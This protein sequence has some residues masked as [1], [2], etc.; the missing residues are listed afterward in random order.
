MASV[1]VITANQ[2]RISKITNGIK[3]IILRVCAYCRVSTDEQARFGF[4]IQAQKDALEKY[5]KQNDYK[6]EFYIDEGISA[7][8]MKKRIALN[9]ML[10]KSN[11]FD[12]VLFTKLDRLS[13]NVLDAN[14][15][16]KLLQDN[17][18]LE[19]EKLDTEGALCLSRVQKTVLVFLFLLVIL[20]LAPNF[21]PKDFF[22]TRS[23][24]H[25]SELQSPR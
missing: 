19:T 6:Y 8:S 17:K 5:C 15:I 20:L 16:N 7:S 18:S 1:K 11:D 14:N 9:E 10:S 25:T 13:R 3:K 21:L 23:E 24:E 4:S 12:M 22:V 2:S